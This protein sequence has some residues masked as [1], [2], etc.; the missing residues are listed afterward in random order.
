MIISNKVIIFAF[1][2]KMYLKILALLTLT[3]HFFYDDLYINF[4][5]YN[6]DKTDSVYIIRKLEFMYKNS[7]KLK[8]QLILMVFLVVNNLIM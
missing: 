8:L 4:I 6:V 5:G 1:L 2:K 7:I 3:N